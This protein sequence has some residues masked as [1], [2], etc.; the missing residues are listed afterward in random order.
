MSTA[1]REIVAAWFDQVWN[2]GDETAIGRL[3]APAA[4]FHGLPSSDGAPIVGPAAFKPFVQTFREA[5][6]D[7]KIS[8]LRTVCEGDLV[9]A[10]CVVT[11]THKGSSLGM[12]ATGRPIS[13]YGMGMAIIR[14][15]QIQESWNYFDFMSLYQQVGALP[16]L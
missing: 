8:I 2:A 1:N 12:Q 13:I 7:I 9:A 15:A 10:H 3:M 5:F 11:G 16:T 6:P 14:D 4:K